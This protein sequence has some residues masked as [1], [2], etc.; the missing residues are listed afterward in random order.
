MLGITPRRGEEIAE[1]VTNLMRSSNN[2]SS[3]LLNIV[4]KYDAESVLAG[5]RFEFLLN[6]SKKN[7][8]IIKRTAKRQNTPLN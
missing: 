1:D 3:A 7:N 2:R 8:D 5:I 4:K 6:M